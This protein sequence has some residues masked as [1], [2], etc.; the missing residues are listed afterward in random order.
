ML[1]SISVKELNRPEVTTAKTNATA[2][3]GASPVHNSISIVSDEKCKL[4]VTI[5]ESCG[6]THEPYFNVQPNYEPI[7][8]IS[9]EPIF[10]APFVAESS[11]Q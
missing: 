4:S 6:T 2:Q 7:A 9:V 11:R 8:R 3:L 10:D 5:S 1:N